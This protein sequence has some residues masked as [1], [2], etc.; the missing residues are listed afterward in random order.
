MIEKKL[1]AEKMKSLVDLVSML[2]GPG[3][4]PWDARQDDSSIKKYLLEEAYEVADAIER[5]KTKEICLELGDLLFQILFLADLAAERGEFNLIDVIE[6]VTAKMIR[7]H[8][9]VFGSESVSGAEEVVTNWDRIKLAEKNGKGDHKSIL[10]DVP[11][12]LP[13]LLRAHTLQQR[14]ER[15]LGRPT[16]EVGCWGHVREAFSRLEDAVKASDGDGPVEGPVGD[17]LFAV[18]ALCRGFGYNAEEILQNTNRRF[19]DD[20][21]MQSTSGDMC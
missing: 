21:E 19:V 5:G 4:C 15:Q 14:A 8:P 11:P 20:F 9:H 3:G 13:A 17:L 18:S 2:R 7:R 16:D 1:L 10:S 12:G 6:G